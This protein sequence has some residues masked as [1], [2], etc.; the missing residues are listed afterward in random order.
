MEKLVVGFLITIGI[1]LVAFVLPL[2]GFLFGAFTGWVVGTVFPET[3][4]QFFVILS[5]SFIHLEP[6]QIG[7]MLGFVGGFFKS[8]S[9]SAKGD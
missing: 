1:G 6:W 4:S 7:G 8:I 2:L 3:F 5:Q 9:F